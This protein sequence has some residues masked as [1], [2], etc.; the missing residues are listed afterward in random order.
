MSH[1]ARGYDRADRLGQQI[2]RE[3]GVLVEQEARDVF[4]GLV[5]I[6][7]VQVTRD[8]HEARVYYS[9]LGAT[10]EKEKVAEWITR[11]LGHF[12]HAVGRVI[13]IRHVPELFFVY[14]ESI[15]AGIR[16]E[17]LFNDI[18]NDSAES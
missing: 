12:R 7:R 13:S 17:Q 5:T 9:Y 8:L 18:R 2:R 6:T 15:E 11:Q 14:D 4:S 16:L 1:A 10:G 3:L